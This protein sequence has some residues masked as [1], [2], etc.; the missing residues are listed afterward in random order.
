MWLLYNFGVHDNIDETATM[1]VWA[2]NQG[3]RGSCL[4]PSLI[5]E[6]LGLSILSFGQMDVLPKPKTIQ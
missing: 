4:K 2:E 1:M 3:K 5:V 6:N